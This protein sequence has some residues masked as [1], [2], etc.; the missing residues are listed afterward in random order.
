MIAGFGYV[1]FGA[2]TAPTRGEDGCPTAGTT[3]I[4]AMLIDASDGLEP[5]D[6]HQV[7]EL[8]SRTALEASSM[9]RF[10]IFT[11]GGVSEADLLPVFSG[12]SL[13]REAGVLTGDLY[14]Q[15]QINSFLAEPSDWLAGLAQ[16]ERSQSPLFESNGRLLYR[17]EIVDATERHLI[18][19]SDLLQNSPSWSVYPRTTAYRS[20]LDGRLPDMPQTAHAIWDSVTILAVQRVA[21]RHL[22]TPELE[23]LWIAYFSRISKSTPVLRKL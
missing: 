22:Q 9:T 13:A 10:S 17:P 20:P 12:C 4:T 8:T 5:S 3:N 7:A 16:S 15:N 21:T 11:A 2:M 23:A 18:F 19:V 6:L 1:G 14:A